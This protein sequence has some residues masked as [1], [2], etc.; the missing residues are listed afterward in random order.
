MHDGG[1]APRR[2]RLY[3][4]CRYVVAFEM[5]MYGFAKVF[6]VQFTTPLSTLDTPLGDVEGMRLV[7]YFFGHSDAYRLLIALGEIGGGVLLLFRR[8]TL[9]GAVVLVPILANI[10]LV[11]A[12]FGIYQPLVTVGV[13]SA[14]VA[15]ILHAHREELKRVFWDDQSS[16]Y[17]AAAGPAPG[18]RR[19]LA[20][21]LKAAMVLVP[22]VIACVMRRENVHPTAIDGKWSVGSVARPAG[23][24]AGST[25]LDSAAMVYFEPEAARWSVIRRGESFRRTEFDVDEAARTLRIREASLR[26]NVLFEGRYAL[27]GD[28]LR[29]AG[30]SGGKPLE[31]LLLR[32]R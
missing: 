13:L 6:R 15:V 1:P 3:T 9:L 4:F 26:G 25:L 32:E 28:T 11:D 27:A 5:C 20:W 12:L 18:G 14:M 2:T 16:V 7:W 31:L 24:A 21:A 29:L 10:V 17:R 19:A 22:A 8:T 30:T 23:F